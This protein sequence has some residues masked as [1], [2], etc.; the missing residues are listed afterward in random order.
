V[1]PSGVLSIAIADRC[2]TPCLVSKRGRSARSEGPAGRAGPPRR[3]VA[4]DDRDP[5]AA[6]DDRD[7]RREV[8]SAPR[9]SSWCD[10]ARAR[11]QDAAV[12]L[13]RG[14][15][16][17]R[18]ASDRTARHRKPV[19]AKT[20]AHQSAT[21]GD[22]FSDRSPDRTLELRPAGRVATVILFRGASPIF[23]R[24]SATVRQFR[25]VLPERGKRPHKS[26]GS[27]SS[28]RRSMRQL[29]SC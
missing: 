6:G 29:R 1:L 27:V 22:G 17:S 10:D 9:W 4:D 15:I 12:E 24:K 26:E 13:G 21:R 2:G 5:E 18:D 11:R 25:R 7:E 14:G 16:P 3:H 8:A 20:V 23:R 28:R 19:C